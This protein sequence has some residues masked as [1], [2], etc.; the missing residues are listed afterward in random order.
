LQ[1][2]VAYVPQQ[3]WIQNNSLQNNILFSKEMKSSFYQKVINA[4]ALQPDID[5]LTSGDATEIGE[6]VCNPLQV[7]RLLII[8]TT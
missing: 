6:N 2:S 5:M 3:A 7:I 1:G 8:S 4:C